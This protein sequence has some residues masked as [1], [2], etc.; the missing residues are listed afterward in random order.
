[1]P[2]PTTSGSR[3][4]SAPGPTRW[5]PAGTTPAT[6]PAPGPRLSAQVTPLDTQEVTGDTL[7]GATW[8]G[9][10]ITNLRTLG[11]NHPGQVTLFYTE[12]AF[13]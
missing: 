3:T 9:V 13:N 8:P 11:T 10:R 5:S 2:P 6:G 1:M 4:S 7:G 12:L